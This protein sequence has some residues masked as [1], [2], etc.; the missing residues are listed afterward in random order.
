MNVSESVG[1]FEVNSCIVDAGGG[2]GVA[3]IDH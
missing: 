1:R 2:E 3:L